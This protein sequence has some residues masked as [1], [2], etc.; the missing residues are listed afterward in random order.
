[1]LDAIVVL[2]YTR[3]LR[4][5]SPTRSYRMSHFTARCVLAGLELFRCGVAGRFVL[6]GEQHGPATSDLERDFLIRRG[7]ESECILN[8]PNRNGTLQQLEPVADLQRKGQLGKVVVVCFGFH[9]DR[10]RSYMRL[11]EICGSIAEV[12][13]THAQFLRE[14]CGSVRVDRE[15]LVDLP[16]LRPVVSAER[17]LIARLLAVDRPFARRA[18]AT[19]LFKV[20]AGP[21]ITDIERGRAHVGLARVD[22]VQKML[23]DVAAAMNRICTTRPAHVTQA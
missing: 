13:Q 4:R 5:S 2:P 22:A 6:P 3:V 9:K 20:I 23:S 14:R 15:E 1:M 7:V 17:G 11:L 8:L 10:V 12:E 16:Q 18:P 19:R 21:T